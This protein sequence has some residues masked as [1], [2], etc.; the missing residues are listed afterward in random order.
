[1]ALMCTPV[2]NLESYEYFRW[3]F[4]EVCKGY[5]FPYEILQED[6]LAW[7]VSYRI[8]FLFFYSHTC[9]LG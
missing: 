4:V 7:K 3:V 1:M 8:L 5:I 6:L 2:Y 9:S